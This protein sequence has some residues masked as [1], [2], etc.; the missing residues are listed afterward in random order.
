[1]GLRKLFVLNVFVVLIAHFGC[2]GPDTPASGV[3]AGGFPSLTGPYLGQEPPGQEPELFAPGVVSTGGQELSICFSP[4]GDDV[5]FFVCG[6]T[7]NPRIILHSRREGPTWTTPRET[8]FFDAERTDSYPF[9]A[10]DGE[11]IFFCSSRA[12]GGS[13][14]TGGHHEIWFADRVGNGWGQPRKVDFGGGLGGSGTFP[15]VAANGNLY[16]NGGHGSG[17]SDIYF[18]RYDGESYTTPERLSDAVNSAGGDFHPF[19]A[20]DESFLLF[21]SVRDD[22]AFG[23]NDLY[24]SI[25]AEDGRWGQAR[26]LGER[27]NT[28]HGEMRPFLTADG[29]YLFFASSR[30]VPRPLPEHPM[31]L[32]EVAR[33]FGGP[34]NGL[35]DIYWVSAEAIAEFL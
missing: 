7:Y 30:P 22:D 29:E 9:V 4:A 33:I 20:P 34:G 19:I 35:Q 10:P 11:R 14:G 16:F 32:G 21:D 1:M 5:Y 23:G 3:D 31:A 18:S 25:R 24:I 13:P 6:P 12:A 28:E 27:L 17:G 8:G 2:S 26:N 15:S